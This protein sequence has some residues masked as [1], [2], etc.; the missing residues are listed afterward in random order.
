M[1]RNAQPIENTEAFDTRMRKII[2]YMPDIAI[3]LIDNKFTKVVGGPGQKYTK[4]FMITNSMKTCLQP[5][6]GILKVG[7]L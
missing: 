3:W 6:I 4:P 5:K 1:M 2:R 7:I